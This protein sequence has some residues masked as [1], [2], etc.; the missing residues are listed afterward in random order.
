VLVVGGGL[1]V[2]VIAEVLVVV[3][4]GGIR[5]VV[6]AWPAPSQEVPNIARVSDAIASNHRGLGE[7]PSEVTLRSRLAS[8]GA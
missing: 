8:S 7:T 2:V 3:L 6:L 4:G 5:A 1:V